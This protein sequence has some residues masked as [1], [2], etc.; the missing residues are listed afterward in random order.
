[1]TRAFNHLVA[2]VRFRE[3]FGRWPL[4]PA[5]HFGAAARALFSAES[6]GFRCAAGR[7]GE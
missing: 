4:P 2:G 6:S 5:N 1:M 7:L 3:K